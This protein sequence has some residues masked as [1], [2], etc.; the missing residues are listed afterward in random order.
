MR[1]RSPKLLS[2]SNSSNQNFLMNKIKTRN[3][4][5]KLKTKNKDE[6]VVSKV[7]ENRYY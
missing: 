3:K 1:L 2:T 6:K 4:A 7:P 5:K